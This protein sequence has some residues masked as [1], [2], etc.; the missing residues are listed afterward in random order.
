MVVVPGRQPM[1]P[2]EPV[3]DNPMPES[4]ISPQSGTKNLATRVTF[5][6][7]FSS[8]SFSI[9]KP[10]ITNTVNKWVILFL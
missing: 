5:H 8:P 2:G 7:T 3:Y 1:Y 4:T 9:K 10:F 6:N